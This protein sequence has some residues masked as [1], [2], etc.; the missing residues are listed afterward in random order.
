MFEKTRGADARFNEIINNSYIEW[1]ILNG[2]TLEE[3]LTK[4]RSLQG[5][6]ES[7]SVKG[8]VELLMRSGF[9]DIESVWKWGPFEGFLA[10]K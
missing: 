1:K 3:V 8:N 7:F 9:K 5:R 10:I 6:M 2:F 4:Q